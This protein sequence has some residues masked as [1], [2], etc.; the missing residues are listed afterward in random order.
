MERPGASWLQ[1]IHAVRAPFA[2]GVVRNLHSVPAVVARVGD[3]GPMKVTAYFRDV[4]RLK[5]PGIEEA[6]I[7]RVIADPLEERQQPDGRYALWGL[8]AEAQNRALRVITLED[9]ETVHNAFFD[10]GFLR[11]MT[12]SPNPPPPAAPPSP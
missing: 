6:W 12:R 1:Q 7:Q 10:R 8:V 3:A 4:V 2:H 5:H 9:R 11:T